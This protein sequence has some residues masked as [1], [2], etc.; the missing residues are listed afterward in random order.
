MTNVLRAVVS[1]MV[2][3]DEVLA[4]SADTCRASSSVRA[5]KVQ[6]S[7]PDEDTRV[8]RGGGVTSAFYPPAEPHRLR[9]TVLAWQ[10][11]PEYLAAGDSS[12]KCGERLML[13]TG[14]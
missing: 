14:R 9:Q 8:T 2:N 3:A 6:M 13:L 1:A 4:E 7:T 10:L 11:W 5:G 12:T